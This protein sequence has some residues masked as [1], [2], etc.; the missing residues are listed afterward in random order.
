MRVDQVLAGVLAETRHPAAGDRAGEARLVRDHAR[1][2][3]RRAVQVLVVLELPLEEVARRQ[4]A[5]RLR[6]VDRRRGPQ[7]GER[8]AAGVV[9]HATAHRPDRLHERGRI[10]YRNAAGPANGDRLEVLRPHH[11]TH[12][13]A[14]RRT[15]LVVHDAS[16]AHQLLA[17]RPDARD[18]QSRN[19]E[20]APQPVL[21]LTDG[22]APEPR[23]IPQ[24]DAVVADRQVGRRGRAPFEDHHVVAREPELGAPVTARVRRGD[25]VGQRAL[26]HDHV[27]GAAGHRGS[28]ERPGGE[29]QLVRR[30]QRIDVRIELLEEIAGGE[31]TPAEV[32]AAPVGAD[33]LHGDPAG[34]QVD[35]QQLARG[36]LHRQLLPCGMAR[37]GSRID[38][39]FNRRRPR[40]D[41]GGPS[42]ST[43]RATARRASTRRARSPASGRRWRTPAA[44]RTGRTS[45]PCRTAAA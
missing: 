10:G 19:P 20:L 21:G 13:A 39:P 27:A 12:A 40:S 18:A 14:A 41:C 9:L 24:L 2:P 23:R 32:V 25:R 30:R 22:P 15:V 11:G 16:E 44:R 37:T 26:G 8:E 45:R 36:Y 42:R 33:L 3:D 17:G 5:E 7:L 29:D 35:S 38:R 28:R 1:V 31:T 4:A 34:R 43:A 6:H